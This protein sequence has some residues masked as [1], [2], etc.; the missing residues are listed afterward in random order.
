MVALS[1]PGWLQDTFNTLVSL[2]DRVILWTN[3][4]KTVDMVYRPCQSAGNLTTEAYGRRVTGVG[5]TY[6]ERKKGQV[7]C[8]ECGEVLEV[9]SLSIHLMNQHGRAA[10]RQRQWSTPAVGVRPQIY[11]MSFPT[12][13][14]P[15]K[16]PVAGCL[17]RVETRTSMRVH[18]VHQY[19][20][21]TGVILEE[22]NFPHPRCALCNMLV[23]RQA[24]NKWHPGTEQCKKWAE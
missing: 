21:N 23:P 3:V 11:R 6:S 22:G 19:V 14:G 24:L 7:A 15:R 20:L 2:F 10:G 5:P 8:G 18:F 9:G 16:C 17:C 12:K 4:G 1:D 13:G